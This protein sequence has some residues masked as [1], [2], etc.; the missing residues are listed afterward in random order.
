MQLKFFFGFTDPR[1]RRYLRL[2]P[3]DFAA[4]SRNQLALLCRVF[5]ESSG[6]DRSAARRETDNTK[7]K[8]IS[9]ISPTVGGQR[10][11][12]KVKVEN[13]QHKCRQN[14]GL[15]SRAILDDFRGVAFRRA[16]EPY[17]HCCCKLELGRLGRDWFLD[18]SKIRLEATL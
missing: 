14:K 15:W 17:A 5:S 12:K 6:P 16:A 1:P 2:R 9:L 8:L 3:G 11:E 7:Q 4:K 13:I 10:R 18:K